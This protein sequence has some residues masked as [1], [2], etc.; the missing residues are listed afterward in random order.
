MAKK[1]DPLIW[2]TIKNRLWFVI[3]LSLLIFS[4]VLYKYYT[5]YFVE[6]E[7]YI[8]DARRFHNSNIKINMK[9]GAI[10]D[11]NGKKLAISIPAKTLYVRPL[12]IKK[13][14]EAVKILSDFFNLD[15]TTVFR[16]L[17]SKKR[18]FLY[19][20]RI[21]FCKLS[22]SLISD[23]NSAFVFSDTSLSRFILVFTYSF[24]FTNL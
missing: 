13:K 12:A 6:A 14:D 8:A 20:K 7:E 16:K 17:Y 21:R 18:R 23:N 24:S 4:Y 3:G 2:K 5:I 9:R 1:I 10:Y 19:F 22:S 11:K 15:Y